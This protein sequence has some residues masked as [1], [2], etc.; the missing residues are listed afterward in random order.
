MKGELL[1]WQKGSHPIANAVFIF[2]GRWNI[3]LPEPA[4]RRA[5]DAIPRADRTPIKTIAVDLWLRRAVGSLAR[6]TIALDR[7][8]GAIAVA[9]NDFLAIGCFRDLGSARFAPPALLD[10]RGRATLLMDLRRRATHRAEREPD[11]DSDE[12][13]NKIIG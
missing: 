1:F 12:K 2:L 11:Q 5:I 3:R 7:D 8:I 13:T 6:G 10:H 9:G 4:G